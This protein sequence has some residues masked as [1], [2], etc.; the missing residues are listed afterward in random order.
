MRSLRRRTPCNSGVTQL[1]HPKELEGRP[2]EMHK[3]LVSFSDPHRKQPQQQ[4]VHT[5]SLPA[6]RSKRRQT[7]KNKERLDTNKLWNLWQRAGRQG[8]KNSGRRY[9]RK[10]S[11]GLSHMNPPQSSGKTTDSTPMGGDTLTHR[12]L[13]HDPQPQRPRKNQKHQFPNHQRS[14]PLPN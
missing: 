6:H 9:N 5:R 14:L 3:Q 4:P 2:Y 12:G 8:G 1:P 10:M 13:S 11:R 7:A